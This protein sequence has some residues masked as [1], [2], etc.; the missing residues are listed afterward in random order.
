MHGLLTYRA[1]PFMYYILVVTLDLVACTTTAIVALAAAGLLYMYNRLA[2]ASATRRG[3]C[4][5]VLHYYGKFTETYILD[6][7]A[8]KGPGSRMLDISQCDWSIF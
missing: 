7:K 5:R 8:I 6:T 3:F 1:I 4:T 2:K